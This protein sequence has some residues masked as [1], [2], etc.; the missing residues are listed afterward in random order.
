MSMMMRKGSCLWLYAG[1]VLAT[2]GASVAQATPTSLK[3]DPPSY[4]FGRVPYGSGPSEPH[5][6]TL[7]NMG[8]SQLTIKRWQSSWAAWWPDAGDP[9]WTPTPSDCHILEPGESCSVEFVFDPLHPGIGTGSEVVKSENAEEDWSQVSFTGEGVGPWIPVT[10]GSLAFGS[11]DVG[12]TTDRQT[13]TLESQSHSPEGFRIESISFTP[14]SGGP[15]STSPFQVVGGTCRVGESLAQGKTCTIEVAMAPTISGEFLS[16]LEITDTAPDSPQS[17][18]VGGT[19]TATAVSNGQ[20]SVQSAGAAAATSSSSAA[21]VTRACPRG[22]RRVVRKG[23]QLCV[24]GV[25]HRRHPP[26]A[27]T[28][29]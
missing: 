20:G 10:P 7:T 13:V 11:V 23:R 6:F 12:A 17:V 21:S 18:E 29:R 14:P 27:K 9:F 26:H 15:L 25:R 2:M 22:K 8:E 3:W 28:R 5:E 1:F 24:K 16:E 4:D 19:A